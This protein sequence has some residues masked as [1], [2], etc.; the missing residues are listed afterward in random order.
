MSFLSFAEHLAFSIL[1]NSQI[2]QKIWRKIFQLFYFSMAGLEPKMFSVHSAI[3]N[4]DESVIFFD[5]ISETYL[6]GKIYPD[7]IF[8]GNLYST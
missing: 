6:I 2:M 3:L 1:K 7:L 5:K 8:V 4:N